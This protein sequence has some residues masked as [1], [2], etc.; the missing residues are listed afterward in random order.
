[1]YHRRRFISL[2]VVFLLSLLFF[3]LLATS[4]FA[5]I[6]ANGKI[7]IVLDPGHGGID[8][9]T[10]G[11]RSEKEYNMDL[12][13]Y[14]KE[15]LEADGHFDVYLTRT[16]DEYL[17]FLP[18][19]LVAVEKNA[20]L[21]L[22][23]HCNSNTES[24]VNGSMAIVSLIEPY[25]ADELANAI[26]DSI[27]D[28]VPVS[29]RRV[30]THE[31]TGDSLGIYYW[32]TQHQ[33]DMPGAWNLG[34][35]SDYYS[36]NT[37]GS[38]FGIPSIIVEHAYLSNAGDRAILDNDD[39]LRAM[40]RAEA[41]AIID[42]YTN[43]EH[44]FGAVSVDFPSSCSMA[45]TQSA[46][47]T[48]CGAKSGTTPLPEAPENHF[49]RVEASLG[50]T[51]TT[52]GYIRYLCQVSFNLN[53]KGYPCTVHRYEEITHAAGHT[54][55][56]TEDTPSLAGKDGQLV[57]TCSTCGDTITEIRS[58]DVHSYEIL[59]NVPATCTDAG[60]IV[61]RCTHC[62]DTYTEDLPSLGHTYE[63]AETT[64][65][66]K[67]H[68]CTVCGD[69]YVEELPRCEHVYNI[70]EIPPTC[71]ASGSR[72]GVCTLCGYAF[73]EEIEPLPHSWRVLTDHS[74]SCTKAGILEQECTECGFHETEH[75][76]P[77]GHTYT[78]EEKKWGKITRVC[79]VC[80]EAFTE[81]APGGFLTHP[82]VITLLV[83]AA[84]S[85]GVACVILFKRRSRS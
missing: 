46:R 54:Y 31:D 81:K 39:N 16:G 3:S 50:A 83:A 65:T 48:I 5:D 61:R 6:A 68:R 23:L 77:T 52:D 10:I 72:S 38:K 85:S 47:C 74:P 60:K 29:R 36:I 84:I 33:W 18:R 66:T 12:A 69:E 70:E 82:I 7:V 58:A 14:V 30:E 28:A 17:K 4:A 59:E 80:G 9:G 79:D 15:Y 27:C 8:G 44:T 20:D 26:V 34:Q 57:H 40:A 35:K 73:T 64:E 1:M 32:S 67:L 13:L 63:I 75:P 49:W 76:S 71:E 2:S 51:C 37:W 56:V 43:H 25:C 78:S 55:T 11:T 22:S 21:L 62:E 45:G 53:D 24:Y 19:A 42:Y 41:D